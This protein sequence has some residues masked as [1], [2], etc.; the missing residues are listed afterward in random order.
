MTDRYSTCSDKSCCD[1]CQTCDDCDGG[2]HGECNQRQNYCRTNQNAASVAGFSNP[3]GKINSGDI[4]IEVLPRDKY[5]KILDCI[6]A[7]YKKGSETGEGRDSGL[8]L[9]VEPE[10]TDFIHAEKTNEIIAAINALNGNV[11]QGV[12]HLVADQ[13][14]VYAS[15]FN[16]IT[17]G[18]MKMQLKD[19]QCP[20]CVSGCNATCDNCDACDSCDTNACYTCMTCNSCNS[21]SSWS[22][23]QWGCSQWSKADVTT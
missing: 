19:T 17:D 9:T 11:V 21:V 10:K 15:Y 1:Q 20:Y 16:A 4:I 18:L 13:H 6:K 3:W 23:S 5:N 2:S 7:A 14:I 22:C 12:P 8:T